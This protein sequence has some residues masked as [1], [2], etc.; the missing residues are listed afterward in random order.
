[1]NALA[2]FQFQTGDLVEEEKVVDLDQVEGEGLVV[3]GTMVEVVVETMEVEVVA[4]VMEMPCWTQSTGLGY[5]RRAVAVVTTN[6]FIS[7]L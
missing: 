2:P 1:M 4:Q 3:V 5:Q 6:V 7:L